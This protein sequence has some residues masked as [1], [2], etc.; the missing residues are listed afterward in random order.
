MLLLLL[1]L[2][3]LKG[4][5]VRQGLAINESTVT[6][7]LSSEF[8]L[9]VSHLGPEIDLLCSMLLLELFP[10]RSLFVL[11]GLLDLE[12]D[13]AEKVLFIQFQLLEGVVEGLLRHLI[14]HLFELRLV[15]LEVLLDS[16]SLGML[17]VR[18]LSE[19]KLKHLLLLGELLHKKACHALKELIT[20]VFVKELQFVLDLLRR[21]R[22]S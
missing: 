21:L 1:S 9:L 13:V 4:L 10:H 20:Q 6:N 3:L 14:F 15:D 8:G 5:L 12:I 19:E 16:I 2:V 7:E 18:V 17:L 11:V 22:S